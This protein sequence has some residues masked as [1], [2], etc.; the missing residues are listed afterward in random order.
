MNKKSVVILMDK[1]IF[2]SQEK[3]IYELRKTWIQVHDGNIFGKQHLVGENG[4]LNKENNHLL[5]ELAK[6]RELLLPL[7]E[8]CS[9]YEELLVDTV[10]DPMTISHLCERVKDEYED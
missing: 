10:S 7:L 3:E 6:C 1:D 4:R 8:D 5:E 9:D 2:E